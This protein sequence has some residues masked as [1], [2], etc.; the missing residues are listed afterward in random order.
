M[1]VIGYREVLPRTMSHRIGEAPT[2][3]RKFAITVSEPVS[4]QTII[5]TIGILHGSPHPEYAYLLCTQGSFSEIDRHHVEA[6]YEYALPAG[7]SIENSDPHPLS[8]P[9]VW[10]FSTGG[11]AI[12][13]FYYYDGDEIAPLVNSAGDIIEG[14]TSTEAELRVTIAGNRATFD[15]A[16][17]TSVT[18]CINDADYLGG[19]PFTWMCTGISGQQ[20]A[21]VVNGSEVR[22]WTF[23]AELV[24]RES[25]HL[26]LVPDSGWQYI[27]Q[28]K[29]GDT[30]TSAGKGADTSD[31]GTFSKT[32]QGGVS[33]LRKKA[34]TAGGVKK[35]A[36]VWMEKI[37]DD[38]KPMRV[39]SAEKVA[40]NDDGSM[41]APG[42]APN[43]LARRVHRAIDF[44]SNF[45]TPT[46]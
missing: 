6:T 44:S 21:E 32:T 22:Y 29:E 27:A 24:Y 40:L 42:S 19:A 10:S 37:N 20:Q 4:H 30:A 17:A 7:G 36:W 39:P 26:L 43:I 8:R 25:S 1:S 11:I 14:F 46:F 45:G 23:T 38:E 16:L 2:A 13:V 18:N 31:T 3:E 5:D 34:R 33:V 41:K 15:Y 12:P 28:D 35:R 9:D